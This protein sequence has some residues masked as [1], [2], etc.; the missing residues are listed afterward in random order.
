MSWIIFL[1]L[2]TPEILLVVRSGCGD[3]IAAMLP[4]M[5]DATRWLKEHNIQKHRS[6]YPV[7]YAY[8]FVKSINIFGK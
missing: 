3:A 7:L 1:R 5:A 8:F 6:K 4:L 2:S